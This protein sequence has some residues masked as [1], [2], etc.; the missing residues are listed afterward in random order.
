MLKITVPLK[1]GMN[2]SDNTFVTL[3]GYELELEH[4]LF[5]LSIWEAREE[6]A[7]LGKQEKTQ[8]QVLRYIRD[9]TRTP[10]VPEHIYDKLSSQNLDD[11]NAYINANMTATTFRDIERE[12]PSREVVTAEIIY[13]WMVTMQIDFQCQHWHLNRLLTLVRVINEKNK[14]TKPK[15]FNRS[16]AAQRAELNRQRRSQHGT[17]G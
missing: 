12:R 15:K 1:E 11:I 8:E 9:M 16:A 3:V 7:F 4:S 17:T 5:S 10:D 13:Y 14:T 6:V 2:E